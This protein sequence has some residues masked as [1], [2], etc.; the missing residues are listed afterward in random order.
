MSTSPAVNVHTE[1]NSELSRDVKFTVLSNARRRDVLR[2]LRSY[3]EPVGI[4]DLAERIAAWE[5]DT[6]P[7]AVTYKQRKRVYTS[8]HQTHLPAL[9]DAGLIEA[10]RTWEG[11]TLTPRARE[12][13]AY[14]D[15]ERSTSEWSNYYFGFASVGLAVTGVAW[16]GLYPFSLLPGLAY[17]T[18]LSLVLFVTALVH[19]RTVRR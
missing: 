6:T 5:N 14:L 19:A 15:G 2:L 10:A 17:A 4:R 18:I 1:Q 8:L 13:D 7:E 9:E 16:V 11:I 12:L 3:D